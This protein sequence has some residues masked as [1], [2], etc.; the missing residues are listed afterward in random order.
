ML[1]LLASCDF[2]PETNRIESGPVAIDALP[3]SMDRPLSAATLFDDLTEL[4]R[5]LAHAPHVPSQSPPPTA[6]TSLTYD[7]YRAIAFRPDSAIWRDESR[8]EVQLFHPGFLYTDP[9]RI[10]VVEDGQVAEVTFDETL[11]EYRD[12]TAHMAAAAARAASSTSD[13]PGYAGF[14]IHY[15]LNSDA[16]KDEVVVFL[17]AS[18]F[19]MLGR[20]HAYGL[21]SRGLAVD[22]AEEG[23]EEFPDFRAFWLLKPALGATT[24]TFFGL[25]EGPSVTGAYRFELEPGAPTVL[26][27]D[28][29]LFAREDVHKL[30]IAPLTSMFL[31]GPNKAPLFDD[32]RPQVHDSDGVLIHASDGEW[33]WRPLTNRQ[34]VQVTPLGAGAPRGFGLVQRER[35]FESYLDMEAAYHRRPSEWV[36]LG[37]GDW[38]LGRV[39]LFEFGTSNE[40]TDNVVAYWVPGDPFRAGDERTFRYRLETFNDRL[41]AQTLAQVERTLIGSDRLPD[42]GAATQQRPRRFIVDFARGEL[43]TVDPSN[44]VTASLLTSSGEVTELLV[45]RLPPGLGYRATWRL[46]PESDAPIDMSVFLV[47]SERPISE[48]WSYLWIPPRDP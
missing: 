6:L 35:N 11:F 39:E 29:R 4:A 21:S 46:Q 48:T 41:E 28:A 26:S 23:G 1:F 12:A 18:Y 10:H 33:I 2:A 45:Q 20:G 31:Y 3:T 15:P 22:I 40:F 43:E 7:E 47:A 5:D 25:L 44:S 38:G 34:G 36:T 37:D 8:F 19:R 32:Y 9:V 30:G 24:V 42:Q 16:S 14:R 17:G 27:V 13:N